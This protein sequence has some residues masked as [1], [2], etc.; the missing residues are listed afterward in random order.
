MTV[1]AAS[2]QVSQA[3]QYQI[4]PRDIYKQYSLEMHPL[5]S[6][7]ELSFSNNVSGISPEHK[8]DVNASGIGLPLYQ[9]V[10]T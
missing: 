9:A 1:H 6:S 10:V 5:L 2:K 3:C 4:V 8:Q 7:A